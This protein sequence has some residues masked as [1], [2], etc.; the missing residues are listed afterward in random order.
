MKFSLGSKHDLL[1]HL[2]NVHFPDLKEKPK[3][4]KLALCMKLVNDEYECKVCGTSTGSDK[5]K[6]YCH[7]ARVSLDCLIELKY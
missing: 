1:N 2:K 6:A 4:P 5:E 3:T 7:I